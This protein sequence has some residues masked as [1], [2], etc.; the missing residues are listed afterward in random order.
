MPRSMLLQRGPRRARAPQGI[1]GKSPSCAAARLPAATRSCCATFQW[2]ISVGSGG[3]KAGWSA[4]PRSSPHQAIGVAASVRE[5]RRQRPGDERV[6]CALAR[7]CSSS[8]LFAPQAPPVRARP[9]ETSAA[10]DDAALAPSSRIPIRCDDRGGVSTLPSP[11]ARAARLWA[12][13]ARLVPG[14]S[15]SS[16]SKHRAAAAILGTSQH[17]ARDDHRPHHSPGALPGAGR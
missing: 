3:A 8:L 16:S 14:H 1:A 11:I 15:S 13:H 2:G 12:S 6:Q 5:F 9:P 7:S 10:D 4:A 17:V